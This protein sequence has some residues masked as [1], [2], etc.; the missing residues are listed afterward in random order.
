MSHYRKIR[1]FALMLGALVMFGGAGVA[2]ASDPYDA[3]ARRIAREERT[4][5]RDIARH[6]YYSRQAENDR[7]ELARLQWECGRR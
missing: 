6:G 7:R 2:Q 5:D 1:L 4:L 3:C